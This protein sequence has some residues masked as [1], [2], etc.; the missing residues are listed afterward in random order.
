MDVVTMRPYRVTAQFS[1]GIDD[2]QSKRLF[3]YVVDSNKKDIN[4]T[5]GSLA[6]F[7]MS[8]MELIGESINSSATDDA[9]IT[10]NYQ[11]FL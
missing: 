9:V 2:Y 3:D 10:L 8:N 4:I 11:G 5:I 1:I 7:T 6:T